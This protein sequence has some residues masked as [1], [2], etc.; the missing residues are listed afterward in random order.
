MESSLQMWQARKLHKLRQMLDNKEDF[1]PCI[2]KKIELVDQGPVN[3]RFWEMDTL[4]AF[5]LNS[6]RGR[7]DHISNVRI[8]ELQQKIMKK[9]LLMQENPRI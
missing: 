3:F 8:V 5:K 2:S 7:A 1:R 9:F 6:Q 4:L